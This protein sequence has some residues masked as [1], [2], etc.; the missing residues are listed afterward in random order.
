MRLLCPGL[1]GH[2]LWVWPHQNRSQQSEQTMG[3][4]QP[5][6]AMTD[7]CIDNCSLRLENIKIVLVLE[8]PV[9]PWV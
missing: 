7:K 2:S 1:A 9:S 8:T 3:M 6:T 4:C 5:D